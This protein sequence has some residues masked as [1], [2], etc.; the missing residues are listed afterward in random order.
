MKL[1]IFDFDGTIADTNKDIALL[2]NMLRKKLGYQSK[3]LDEITSYI[4]D[5]VIKLIERSVPEY[6]NPAEL[7]E[8]FIDLY[9]KN[10]VMETKLYPDVKE[11]LSELKNRNYELA[12]LTN[13]PENIARKILHHFGIISMFS[14]VVGEDTL[15]YRKPDPEVVEFILK[16]LNIRGEETTMVGDGVNDILVAK[17]GA[18]TSIFAAYGYSAFEKMKELNPDYVIDKFSDLLKIFPPL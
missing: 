4:G 12:I 7:K 6:H 1:I 5:G 2:T 18:I 8:I 9:E 16:T 15:P 10:P 13:K 3:S 17:N 14:M 11:T